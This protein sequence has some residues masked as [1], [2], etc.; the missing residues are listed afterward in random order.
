M[1]NSLVAEKIARL[2][3]RKKTKIDGITYLIA[4]DTGN[5]WVFYATVKTKKDMEKTMKFNDSLGM[6]MA[7]NGGTEHVYMGWATNDTYEHILPMKYPEAVIRS[8]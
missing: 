1:Q 3:F 6:A 8:N 7:I 5:T 4:K 2:K